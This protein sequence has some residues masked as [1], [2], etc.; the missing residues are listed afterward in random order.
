MEKQGKIEMTFGVD[1]GP[2]DGWAPQELALIDQ[3][4]S[5]D[6]WMEMVLAE[7]QRIYPDWT[8]TAEYDY[9]HRMT[10]TVTVYPAKGVEA[11]E[12]QIRQDVY[13][14]SQQVYGRVDEWCV[15]G[16]ED[17]TYER[18]DCGGDLTHYLEVKD[19]QIVR[20]WVD[21][22]GRE[23]NEPGFVEEATGRNAL[24]YMRDAGYRR[25]IG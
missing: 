2:Y 21:M 19:G 14:V 9:Y 25:A 4:A 17:G 10:D 11:D 23:Y 1:S 16:V 18:N 22:I 12:E 24:E 5:Y 15:E 3:A 6:K 20:A 8:V 7:V 13:E